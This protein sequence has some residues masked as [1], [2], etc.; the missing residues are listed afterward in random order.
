MAHPIMIPGKKRPAGTQTPY[1]VIVK[2]YQIMRY[3]TIYCTGT[4]MP[5]GP[6]YA[7]IIVLIAPTSSFANIVASGSY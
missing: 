3:E 4:L 6:S 5:P 1:V 2:R 7:L